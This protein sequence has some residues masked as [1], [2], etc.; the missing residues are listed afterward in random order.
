M[1]CPACTEALRKPRV[2]DFTL[3][4]HSCKAR[5]L[6]CTGAHLESSVAGKL[7]LSYRGVLEALF[8]EGWR[9]GGDEVK[10]WAA[11]MK[12]RPST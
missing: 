1:T 7:T 4:C 9:A 12:Q 11:R 10:V 5:A 2:N 6:A 8:G 3:G